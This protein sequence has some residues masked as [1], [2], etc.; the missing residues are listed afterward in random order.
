MGN[1]FHISYHL[2]CVQA[3][4]WACTPV[5][6]SFLRSISSDHFPNMGLNDVLEVE[7]NQVYVT[8]WQPFSWPERGQKQPATLLEGLA[9]LAHGTDRT[10]PVPGGLAVARQAGGGGGWEV[11]SVLNHDGTKLAQISGAAR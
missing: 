4:P 10:V 5:T 6:L 3:L 2:H 1:I 8:Q 7:H 11:E 9:V